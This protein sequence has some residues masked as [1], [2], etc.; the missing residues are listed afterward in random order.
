[1]KKL[2]TALLF[3]IAFAGTAQ[4][5]IEFNRPVKFTAVKE[6]EI[7]SIYGLTS[8]GVM[9]WIKKSDLLAG[10][11]SPISLTTIGN[12]GASTLLGNVFNIRRYDLYADSKVQ[13]SMT[14]LS[15]S[16]APS[17]TAV[18]N[19]LA[20]YV[21]QFVSINEGVQ[22]WGTKY[23]ADNPNNYGN[24]GRMATDLTWGVGASSTVGATGQASF[25]ANARNTAAGY[26]SSAFG[27]W[28][29]ANG[30]G[31]TSLGCFGTILT[32]GQDGILPLITNRIFNVGN[33]TT[34]ILRSNAFTIMMNGIATLPSVTN[35]LITAEATGKAIVT[36]EY[37]DSSISSISSGYVPL[38]GVHP[39]KQITGPLLFN[40]AS[41]IE[42]VGGNLEIHRNAGVIK[43]TVGVKANFDVE[44]EP[45]PSATEI[46]GLILSSPNGSRWRITV[47]DSGVLTTTSL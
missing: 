16:V 12:S 27:I 30:H 45:A 15:T 47:S 44:I 46:P 11:G 8:T 20:T 6:A 14:P 31:E 25:T 34:D 38:A 35:A 10:A 23:R 36:R 43:F 5:P 1:M 26:Y 37:V 9:G 33:G 32:A 21:P 41:R 7:D 28:N 39:L 40:N 17:V 13:N 2:F 4:A 24:I 22:G 42:D 18:S 19:A 29:T 3:L